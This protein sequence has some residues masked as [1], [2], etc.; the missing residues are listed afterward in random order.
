MFKKKGAPSAKSLDLHAYKGN[1][2]AQT[3]PGSSPI[4]SKGQL[5]DR[6]G[7]VIDWPDN[8]AVHDRDDDVV[9]GYAYDKNSQSLSGHTDSVYGKSGK[10]NNGILGG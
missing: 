10:Y 9:S 8:P 7:L 1:V 3:N 5:L 6:S 2:P 4:N